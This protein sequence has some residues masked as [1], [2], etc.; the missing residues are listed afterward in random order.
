D[1]ANTLILFHDYDIVATAIP[2]AELLVYSRAV[3]QTVH[4]ILY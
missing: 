2:I 3:L 4:V 1:L